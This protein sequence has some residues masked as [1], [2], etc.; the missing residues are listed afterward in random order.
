MGVRIFLIVQVKRY[1]GHHAVRHEGGQRDA[2]DGAGLP[3]GGTEC[4]APR[5]EHQPYRGRSAARRGRTCKSRAYTPG[6]G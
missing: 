3:Y 1:I 4:Q 6:H 2:N 5:Q